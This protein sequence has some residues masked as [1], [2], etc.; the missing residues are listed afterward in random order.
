MKISLNMFKMLKIL[1]EID[2][3]TDPKK[4]NNPFKFEI[5]IK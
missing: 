1:L 4:R 3:Q 2:Y 5:N